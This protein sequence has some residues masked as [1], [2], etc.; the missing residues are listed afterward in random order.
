MTPSDTPRDR[1]QSRDA[2]NSVCPGREVDRGDL[3]NDSHP[4]NQR[5]LGARGPVP[6][7]QALTVALC[8]DFLLMGN[9]LERHGATDVCILRRVGVIVGK[10]RTMLSIL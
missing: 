10:Q 5:K 7:T 3:T 1:V 9:A 4:V 6:H 8:R 2:K